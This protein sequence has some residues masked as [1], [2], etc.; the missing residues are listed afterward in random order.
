MV[1]FLPSFSSLPPDCPTSLQYK[2]HVSVHRISC[3]L[4][5]LLRLISP[6]TAGNW[7]TLGAIR[8]FFLAELAVY[9]FTAVMHWFNRFHTTRRKLACLSLCVYMKLKLADFLWHLVGI[10]LRVKQYEW[11]VRLLL[12]LHGACLEGNDF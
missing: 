11:Q 1:T 6:L 10:A 7:I 4:E 5:S 2:F 3:I 12:P 9:G 8:F